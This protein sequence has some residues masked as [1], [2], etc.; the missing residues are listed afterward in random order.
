MKSINFPKTNL[1]PALLIMAIEANLNALQLHTRDIHALLQHTEFS[2]IS[3]R[4]HQICFLHEWVQSNLHDPLT[5]RELADI[6]KV[7]ER[8]V[9][10]TLGAGPQQPGPLGRHRAL[11]EK[12]E[13]TLVNL[14]LDSYATRHSL[15]P[16]ELVQIM[17]G[18]YDPKLTKGWVNAFIGRHLDSVQVCRSWPQEDN[19]LIISRA[20]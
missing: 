14:I 4:S 9:R 17:R 20:I 6:F 7:A 2:S 5:T 19:Q 13:Q 15:T 8:T 1:Q 3:F 10:R 18:K 11:D 12:S 16:K